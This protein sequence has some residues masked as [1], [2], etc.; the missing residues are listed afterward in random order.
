MTKA[1][2]IGNQFEALGIPNI[3][4]ATKAVNDGSIRPCLCRYTY[5][6]EIDGDSYWAFITDVGYY[7][8]SGCRWT[9]NE[10]VYFGVDLRQID[11]FV[12]C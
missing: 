3:S 10:W 2:V 11:S 4:S 6:W 7:S 1:P 8:I 12:C 9:G 5:I